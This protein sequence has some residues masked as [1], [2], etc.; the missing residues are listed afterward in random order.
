[1]RRGAVKEGMG[2]IEHMKKTRVR[3]EEDKDEHKYG[4]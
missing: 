1:V 2:V 4:K 3:R